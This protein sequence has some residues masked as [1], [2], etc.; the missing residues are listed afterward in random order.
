MDIDAWHHWLLLRPLLVFLLAAPVIVAAI[1]VG[2]RQGR[3]E[4]RRQATRAML[5]AQDGDGRSAAAARRVSAERRSKAGAESGSTAAKAAE[6]AEGP[7]ADGDT[8]YTTLTVPREWDGGPLRPNL[9]RQAR[10]GSGR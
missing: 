5:G 2:W 3:K 6:G 4:G 1:Y 8:Y 10:L 7:V 9:A